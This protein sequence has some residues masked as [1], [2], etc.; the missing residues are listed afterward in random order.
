[1]NALGNAYANGQG[2]PQD[3]AVAIKFYTQALGIYRKVYGASAESIS[4]IL[5]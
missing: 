4:C 1:L 3:F 2:V 5:L